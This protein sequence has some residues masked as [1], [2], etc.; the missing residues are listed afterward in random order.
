MRS[1][2]S[3]TVKSQQWEDCIY[4]LQATI[5]S[6]LGTWQNCC[7]CCSFSN[8]TSFWK[9]KN[10]KTGAQDRREGGGGNQGSYQEARGLEGPVENKECIFGY[11]FSISSIGRA[12]LIFEI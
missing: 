9:K 10:K 4:S 5:F 11:E 2:F 1:L 6:Q 8:I 7:C 12:G 3:P